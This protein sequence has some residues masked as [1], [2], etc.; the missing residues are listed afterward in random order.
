MGRNDISRTSSARQQIAAIGMT[1]VSSAM[2]A[3]VPIF[4]KLAYNSGASILVV[5]LGRTAVST[6]LL[7]FALIVLRQSFRASNRVLLL[8]VIG[9]IAGALTSLGLLGSVA[10]ID[11]SLAMLIVYLHPMIIAFIGRIRGTYKFGLVR[12][13]CCIVILFGL[14]LHSPSS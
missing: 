6:V 13:F 4:A 1:L 11:I 9:G 12:V 8:C 2:I 5:V 10:S 3:T 14:A 7:A